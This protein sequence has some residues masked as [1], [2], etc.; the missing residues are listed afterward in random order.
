MQPGDQVE[1]EIA[2]VAFGGDGVARLGRSEPGPDGGAGRGGQVVFVPFVL[3]GER[4]EAVVTAVT[5]RFARAECRR[6]LAPSPQRVA[7]PCPH[8]G[9]C[10]GCRYQH[11]AWPLQ[12]EMKRKQGVDVLARIGGLVS[13][14]VEAVAFAPPEYGCRNKL[15][16]HGP[17][18]PGFHRLGGGLLPIGHCPLACEAINGKL[19]ELADIRLE[20]GED[21][22]IRC[23]SAG[24]VFSFRVCESGRSRQPPPTETLAE[25]WGGLT[26]RI[27]LH[28]FAQVNHAVHGLVLERLGRLFAE[29][30]ASNLV[31]AYC[32]AGVFALSLAGQAE[33]VIGIE[34]DPAAVACAWENA[35]ALGAGQ[36][37]FWRGRVEELLARALRETGAEQTAVILDP[38]RAGCDPLVLRTLARERP[39]RI[40][41]LSCVPPILARDLKILCAGGYAVKR[42]LPFDMFPQTAHMEVLAELGFA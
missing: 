14:P 4:V 27:P 26:C 40:F 13:P 15:T 34:S 1:L 7:P 36:A 10:G 30:P 5:A 6:V 19:G 11:A 24:E 9:V 25:T 22:T 32:G 12:L 35:A 41:Y 2:D 33:R 18:R 28:S 3:P 17:G 16:L 8:F 29:G 23:S 31:D 20:A 37:A 39:R 42:V 21:L 38:P